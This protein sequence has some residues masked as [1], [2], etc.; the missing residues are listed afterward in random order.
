MSLHVTGSGFFNPFL[1]EK[2]I[3][4]GFGGIETEG[5]FEKSSFLQDSGI[6]MLVPLD[7]VGIEVLVAFVEKPGIDVPV[8]FSK[9]NI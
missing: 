1:I 2:S 7:E 9:V 6:E 5:P 4:S 3:G 8:P